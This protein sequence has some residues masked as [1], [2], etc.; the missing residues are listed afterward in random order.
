[1]CPASACGIGHID[2]YLLDRS[3]ERVVALGVVGGDRRVQ[4]HADVGSLDAVDEG[5]VRASRPGPTFFPLIESVPVPPAP[6]L[7]P[8]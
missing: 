6:G 7:P 3:G 8:S 1:M 2:P 5:I 4:V